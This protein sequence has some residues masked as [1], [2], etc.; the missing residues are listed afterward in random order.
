[1]KLNSHSASLKKSTPSFFSLSLYVRNDWPESGVGVEQAVSDV[2]LRDA[3]AARRPH[4]VQ[5]ARRVVHRLHDAAAWKRRMKGMEWST[6]QL[7]SEE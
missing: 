5:D 4:A 3:P 2:L 6:A 7:K 1:M